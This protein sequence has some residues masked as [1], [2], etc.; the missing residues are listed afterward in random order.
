MKVKNV[1]MSEVHMHEAA[2]LFLHDAC[3]IQDI[4]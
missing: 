3:S 4:Q 1:P 2:L